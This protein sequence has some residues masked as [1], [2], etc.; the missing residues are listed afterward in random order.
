M[1]SIHSGRRSK[2]LG[3][4]MSHHVRG[5]STEARPLDVVMERLERWLKLERQHRHE[6]KG[7]TIAMRLK[8]E[9][10]FERDRQLVLEQHQ[11]KDSKPFAL[12]R[13]REKLAFFEVRKPSKMQ[14]RWLD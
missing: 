10:E 11:N 8:Y 1:A 5:V 4:R 14:D 13:C 6:V 12:E 2:S 3:K 7:K 9:L